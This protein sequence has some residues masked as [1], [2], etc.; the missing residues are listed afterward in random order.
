MAL[1]L[2]FAGAVLLA[3]AVR[4]K[5]GDLFTLLKGDLTGANNFVFW[6]VALVII[7]SIG[8]IPRLKPLSVA[9]LALVLISIFL[10]KG[11][12]FFSGLTT[13]VNSTTGSTGGT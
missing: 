13:A 11:T 3:A 5:Q 7:G 10:R 8:F 2:L 9:L 4:S 1:A 6:I 12:G